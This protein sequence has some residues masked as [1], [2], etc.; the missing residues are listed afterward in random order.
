MKDRREMKRLCILFIIVAN[1]LFSGCSSRQQTLPSTISDI[2]VST[3]YNPKVRFPDTATYA[4]LRVD[5][6]KEGLPPEAESIAKRVREA[7]QYGLKNKKYK[8]SKGEEIDYLIDYRI[9]AQ[10]NVKILTERT[11]ISGLE[12]LSVVGIPDNFIKGSLVFDVI[13]V[14]TLKPVWR[15]I[16]NANIALSPVSEQEKETRVKYAVRQLL[17]TFPPN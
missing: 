7:L 16:C 13:D 8:I 4:F 6:A 14:K 1:I 2:V 17:R 5:P 15:G 11:K 9:V 10:Q 3:T 12:W